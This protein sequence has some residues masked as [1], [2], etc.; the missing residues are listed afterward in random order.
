[1]NFYSKQYP[2]VDDLVVVQI[3]SVESYAVRVILLEYNN[4]EAMISVNE[5]SRRHKSIKFFKIGT[6]YVM[7]V[8]RIDKG[9]IDLTRKYIIDD[10][11]SHKIE[12]FH[13][14]KKLYN[15]IRYVSELLH[16]DIKEPLERF[17]WNESDFIISSILSDLGT[18]EF[19]QA[20]HR[21]ITLKF[22][23]ENMKLELFFDLT[24]FT[25]HG[26]DAIKKSLRCG[27]VDQVIIKLSSSPTYRMTTECQVYDE[28]KKKIYESI[29]N[30][31]FEI[32][33]WGGKCIVKQDIKIL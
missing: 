19:D 32:A 9:L 6:E 28:G 17:I 7:K 33:Q 11:V 20:L 3:F 23:V 2:E 29:E 1:M 24:C 14:I 22:K 4:I 26:I 30:I 27:Y 8:L 18:S 25:E 12:L 31:S 5:L 16:V 21:E 10:E 13:K 15:A